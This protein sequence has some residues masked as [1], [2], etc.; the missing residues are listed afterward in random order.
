MNKFLPKE[1][2]LFV[3]RRSD[4][5]WDREVL[6]H[7][8]LKDRQEEAKL[9]NSKWWDYRPIHPAHATALFAQAY[10]QAWRQSTERRLGTNSYSWHLVPYPFLDQTWNPF[11]EAKARAKAFW[12]SRRYCDEAGMPYDFYCN[13][14]FDKA[15]DY[16]EDL[17]RPQEMYRRDVILPVLEDWELLSASGMYKMPEH[18]DYLLRYNNAN[19]QHQVQWREAYRKWLDRSSAPVRKWH[20]TENIDYLP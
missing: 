2:I 5:Q 6:R 13:Q 8:P 3:E 12:K 11:L 19:K 14:F 20:L 18:E 10:G 16:F 1:A 9:Y 7:I 4:I 17:P 15:E